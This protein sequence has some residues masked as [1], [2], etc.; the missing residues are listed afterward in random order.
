MVTFMSKLKADLQIEKP[1]E[2]SRVA[3]FQVKAAGGSG[4]LRAM[5]LTEA[6]RVA[7]P[8]ENWDDVAVFAGSKK[9]TQR[10]MLVTVAGLLPGAKVLEEF[11]HDCLKSS[12]RG[13]PGDLELDVFLPAHDLGLYVGNDGVGCSLAWN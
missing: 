10:Q 8:G 13:K 1:Q 3:Q 6:L 4:L 7:F 5:S 9:A 11:R 2:W 12:A